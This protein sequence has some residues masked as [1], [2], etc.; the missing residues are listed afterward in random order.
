M[1]QADIDD[2]LAG[3]VSTAEAARL[4]EL[5]QRVQELERANEI[6]RRASVFLAAELDRRTR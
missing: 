6:L 1:R 2:R 5:Q 3:G 4:R